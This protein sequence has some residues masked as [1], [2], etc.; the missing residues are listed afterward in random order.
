MAVEWVDRV[1]EQLET[2]RFG[3]AL[4]GFEEVDSTNVQARA[5]AQDGAEEGSVV[6]ADYQTHGRGRHGRVWTADR[7]QNLMLSTVLRPSLAPDALGLVTVAAG[8]AVAEAVDAFA[9][10]HRADIKWPNDVLLEERKTCGMLLEGSVTGGGSRATPPDFVIL[11]IGLNV[12]QVHFPE[13]LTETATSLRLVAGRSV[14]RV[15][16]LAH[17]LRRLEHRY[18]QVQAG[19]DAEV[20]RRFTERMP[21]LGDDVILRA[22]GSNQTV[23]GRIRGITSTGGLRLATP[24]GEQVVHAGEVTTARRSSR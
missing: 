21:R 16:L 24:S 19:Q 2:D 15:P 4:R 8:V 12:N 22:T 20:R 3:R 23:A 10:T 13:A 5:W 14:P 6:V 7:G 18:D 17:L 9:G 1:G 11:G